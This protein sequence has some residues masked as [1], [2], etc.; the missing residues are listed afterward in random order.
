MRVGDFYEAYGADAEDLARSLN[1]ILTTKE[2]GKGTRVA[3]SGVPYHSVDAYLARLMRQRRVVAIAEQ[4]EQPVPNR[5][6]RREIVRVLTPGTVL[7]DQFLKP[8]RNN[9][10]CAF[11]RAGGVTAIAAADV[12]TGAA[13]VRALANDDETAAELE[14]L[15]PAELI[16]AHEEDARAVKAF[17]ADDCRI[18]VEPLAEA[19][20]DRPYRAAGAL[21][22]EERAAAQRALRLLAA[23]LTRLKFDGDALAGAAAAVHAESAMLIDAATRRHLDLV[24]GS[25]ENSRASLLGVLSKTRTPMGSRSLAARLC[26]PLV[27]AGEIER[28]LDRV[29]ALHGKVSLRIELQETLAAIG[30]IERVVQ[31]SRARRAAPRDLAALRGS[32]HGA[33]AVARIG[34]TCGDDE[35]GRLC[36]RAD[37]DGSAARVADLLESQ[38]VAD[39]PPTLADGGVFNPACSATLE[40]ATAL[41]ANGKQLLVDLES[42]VRTRTGIRSLKVKYTQSLGYY[43]EVPRSAVAAVPDGF[44]RKQSLANAE[45]FTGDE[46]KELEAAIIGAKSRQVAAE[47]ELFDSLVERIEQDASALLAA[48]AAIAELDVYCSLAQVA[49]ERRYVRP[50]ISETSEIDVSG[51]RHPIVEAF[52]ERDF[53]ANDCGAAAI[54]RFLLITG[55]NMGGKSTYLRQTALLSILAQMGSFVPAKRARLGIVDRLF[56]RIGAGDDIAAGRSTFFVEMEEM[57]VI[58]RRCTARSL[59]L[60]DEVGR[61][62]GTVDGLAIAQAVCEHLLAMEDVM[63]IVLFATHFHELVTLSTQHPVICNLHVVVAEERSGPVFSHRLLPGASSRSYGIAVAEMAGLPRDVIARAREIADALESRPQPRAVLARRRRE[64]GSDGQLPLEM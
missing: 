52:G 60:I 44:I 19:V 34:R 41:R 30:D 46:L 1:I 53:I 27:D 43:F 8:E 37:A 16:A 54:P 21:A 26:A 7:E 11:V 35:I 39:P 6:V 56:T 64:E 57:A 15:A 4:M 50:Q 18:A 17:V 63:P 10:L 23:Y 31:K 51:G 47:R 13:T 45:R 42:Q 32:L 61:G 9:Y 59:L 22:V 28:R 38:L 2:S 3:M 24:A 29:E 33:V 55:P 40:E 14:R 25:G 20:A 48:A 58:L 5:L 62:T 36:A 12:S 49:G